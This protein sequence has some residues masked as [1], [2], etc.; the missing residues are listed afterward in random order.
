MQGAI[1]SLPQAPA[2][3][4]RGAG[5]TTKTGEIG[6]MDLDE[7]LEMENDINR[8]AGPALRTPVTRIALFKILKQWKQTGDDNQLIEDLQSVGIAVCDTVTEVI[9]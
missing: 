5:T 1:N 8:Q 4:L 9:G 7:R 6:K 3:R 2:L